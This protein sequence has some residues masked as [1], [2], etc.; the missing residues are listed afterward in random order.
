MQLLTLKDF[1]DYELIDSGGGMRLE[2]FGTVVISKPDPQALWE[3]KAPIDVWN[4]VHAL[5]ND[6]NWLL[7]KEIPNPWIVNFEEIKL[8]ARLTPFKHV[9]IF[10][11]QAVFWKMTTEIIKNSCIQKP[12]VLNLFGYTGAASISLAKGGAFVTHV[13]ASKPSI[14]YAKENMLLSVLPDNSIRWII[15][16]AIKFT[17]REIKRGNFYDGIIL[18]PP[19]YGHGPQ[20]EPW[21]FYKNINQLLLNCKK[22][23][24]PKP[25]FI[26]F[27]AYAISSSSLMLNHLLTDLTKNLGGK[28]TSG[29]LVI[30]ESFGKRLLSTGIY[31]F[32]RK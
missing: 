21:D 1:P 7:K 18:D 32:W 23:L 10:P 30:E 12:K 13:D 9:G 28:I 17:S 2:R 6:G 24:S 11:E 26:I 5:F 14:T 16:D 25:M 29:E 4:N 20:G 22:I 15:D 31:S 3:R 27:N 19:V 8:H